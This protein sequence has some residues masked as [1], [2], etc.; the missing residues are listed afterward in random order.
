MLSF[1][2]LCNF[3][4]AHHVFLGQAWAEG[5]GVQAMGGHYTDSG[6]ELDCT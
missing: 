2:F 5:K 6:Q 3:L 4:G 1:H